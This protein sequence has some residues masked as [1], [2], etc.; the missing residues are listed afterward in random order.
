MALLGQVLAG[1]ADF[2]RGYHPLS[3]FSGRS[4]E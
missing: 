3:S 4:H 1:H 2:S